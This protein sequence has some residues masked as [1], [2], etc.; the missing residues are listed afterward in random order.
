[1][2][3]VTLIMKAFGPYGGEE[4]ICFSELENRTMFVITG[5]TGAG[6]TT[7]FDGISFAI[8]GKTNGDERSGTD[9]R[10]QFA[11]D[12]V[13][14]EV[15]LHFILKQKEYYI[16]RSPQQEKKKSRGEGFTTIN[17]KAEL[18]EVKNDASKVLISANVRDVDEKIKEL[19]Q[20]DANQFRQILMIPQGEFRKLLVSDSKE[21]EAIL[22]KLFHTEIFKRIEDT[23]KEEAKKI[24]ANVEKHEMKMEQLYAQFDIEFESELKEKLVEKKNVL[25]ELT[26]LIEAEMAESSKFIQSLQK[27]I[28]LRKLEKDSLQQQFFQAK[29]VT[30][31]FDEKER[32]EQIQIELKE[33]QPEIKEK[34]E[35]IKRA[36]RAVQIERQDDICHSIS[37]DLKKITS[38]E[39]EL[40]RDL[41]VAI[42]NLEKCQYKWNKEQENAS[43]RKEASEHVLLLEK[44]NE[45]IQSYEQSLQLKENLVRIERQLKNKKLQFESEF[46]SL[47]SS[48]EA[49]QGKRSEVDRLKISIMQRER[50]IERTE[51]NI[52]LIEEWIDLKVKKTQMDEKLTLLTEKT[53]SAMQEWEKKKE[54]FAQ[55]EDKWKKGQA[56]FIA[57][58]LKDNQPCP[59]CGSLDHPHVASKSPFMLTEGEMEGMKEEILRAEV[60]MKHE[61]NERIKTET[62]YDHLVETKQ[63]LEL[64]LS[65]LIEQFSIENGEANLNKLKSS[66]T[67]MK[68]EEAY[69]KKKLKELTDTMKE[70]ERLSKSLVEKKERLTLINEEWEKAKT[71]LVQESTRYEQ[72]KLRLPN[73]YQTQSAFQHNIKKAKDRLAHLDFEYEQARKNMDQAKQEHAILTV[74]LEGK[75]EEAN[76]VK[77]SMEKERK[78]FRELMEQYEF[79]TYLEF[80]EAKK[81]EKEIE[82]LE[83]QIKE[84]GEVSRSVLDRL[85]QLNHN[86]EQMNRPHLE[87]IEN[88]LQALS[89]SISDKENQWNRSSLR[90]EKNRE[91]FDLLKETQEEVKEFEEKYK[92]LGNLSDMAKGNNA[93]R[94]TF[95][96]YVLA[97]YLD[98]ILRIANERLKDMTNGRYELLRKTDRSKGNVQSG[99]ELLV[100][101]QYTGY[102]R[103]VKTLSGGESFKASL[104]LALGLA[105]VV[106][107]HAGGVSL[108]T[109]FIDEGFGT[110]DPESLDQAIETLM[111][112]Q[113]SGRLVGIISHVPDLKERIDARLEVISTTQGSKT[114]F[115]FLS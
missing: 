71:Q 63:V 12:L 4:K 42:Q 108:E 16:W 80:Q 96:R 26:P 73:G 106:Q 34:Q 35:S 82:M 23:L 65:T 97:S 88:K 60:K 90:D 10:S 39:E 14:T 15:S 31:Q 92:V 112:I 76:R 70:L 7:I 38:V 37:I 33:K 93:Q 1:M 102:E 21:K 111:D 18:Y 67:E 64:K 11:D 9:L 24:Y 105:D 79:N 17:A 55:A 109:M 98:D 6:K 99:L 103:H 68:K 28:N 47:Q 75:K 58:S 45:D 107:A 84:Y 49:I 110:L 54:K 94:L 100:F 95:E 56:G 104:S 36:L 13:Q 113:S 91:V 114:R 101:D 2:K 40:S 25:K 43:I 72:L 78:R 51:S 85:T 22:Q 3:P 52:V 57:E 69:D 115:Q 29:S 59:V 32:L 20:L 50:N 44:S 61:E 86:L 89:L 46:E 87:T 19:M 8:Y 81:S 74:K 30:A 48:F 53:E 5:K 62:T 27:E 66:M 77:Q 83:R 41:V